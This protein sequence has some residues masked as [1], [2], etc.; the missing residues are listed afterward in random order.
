MQRLRMYIV[1]AR[2]LGF[3]IVIVKNHLLLETFDKSISRLVYRL[4][5]YKEKKAFRS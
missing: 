2:H 4:I 3:R 5:S 1:Q